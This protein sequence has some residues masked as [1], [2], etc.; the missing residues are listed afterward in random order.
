MTFA[1]NHSIQRTA[2]SRS[3]QFAC[4]AQRPLAP[5]HLTQSVD[6]RL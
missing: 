5:A 6:T 1:P 2:A 3:A 4:V